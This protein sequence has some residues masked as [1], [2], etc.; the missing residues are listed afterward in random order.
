MFLKKITAFFILLIGLFCTASA[1]STERYNLILFYADW[2]VYSS[3]AV[4]TLAQVASISPEITFEKINIDDKKAFLR[5]KRHGVMPTNSIP[6]YFLMDKNDKV[7]YGSAYK[8]ESAKAISA[9]IN[10]KIQ[11]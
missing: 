7:L 8:N 2:N 6:Y 11:D 3:Q 9:I 5:M 4:K 1:Y 10:K